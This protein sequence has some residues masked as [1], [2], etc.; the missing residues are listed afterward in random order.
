MTSQYLLFPERFDALE[1][2]GDVGP[3]RRAATHTEPVSIHSD[4]MSLSA[5]TTQFILPA[6]LKGFVT[7]WDSL[8]ISAVVS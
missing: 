1:S 4:V 6:P 3:H 5:S 7:L 8:V 2:I